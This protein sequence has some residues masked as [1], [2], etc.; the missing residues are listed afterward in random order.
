MCWAVDNSAIKPEP[1]AV[2]AHVLSPEL[3][4][5]PEKHSQSRNTEQHR[6][7]LKYKVPLENKCYLDYNDLKCKNR[8]GKEKQK[9]RDHP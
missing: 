8:D 7:V 4:G 6:K 3:S 2:E 5:K 1:L 9:R